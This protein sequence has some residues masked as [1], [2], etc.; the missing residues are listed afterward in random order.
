MPPARE[1]GVSGQR[2]A[3][4]VFAATLRALTSKNGQ[5]PEEIEPPRWSGGFLQPACRLAALLLL[6]DGD[7]LPSIRLTHICVRTI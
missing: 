2:I 5:R 3:L 7:I 6:A 1:H 4:I